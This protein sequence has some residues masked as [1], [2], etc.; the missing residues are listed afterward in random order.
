MSSTARF[1]L[2]DMDGTLVSTNQL[3]DQAYR[4]V[5][6]H[7]GLSD[8]EYDRFKGWKTTRVFEFLGFKGA[9]LEGLVARKQKIAFEA[10]QNFH[11]PESS[12]DLLKNLHRQG[13]RQ[14]IVTGASERFTKTILR[15]AL[16]AELFDFLITAESSS[17]SKPH[18]APFL[19]AC[20]RFKVGPNQCVV[21]E[22]SLEVL[23]GLLPTDFH[24]R[25]LLSQ[26]PL[27]PTNGIEI[28]R[29][30]QELPQRLLGRATA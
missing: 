21:V 28:L 2:W 10:A 14:A 22:D 7:T 30:L 18:P 16:E 12:L 20:E 8:F 29:E 27:E 1:V 3:H 15:P 5:L 26:E 19:L 9:E 17:F 25:F 24:R 11:F 23:H 6:R 13:L 4:E